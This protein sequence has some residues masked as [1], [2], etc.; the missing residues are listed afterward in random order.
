ML[1]QRQASDSFLR[2]LKAGDRLL[3]KD[4]AIFQF[5]AKRTRWR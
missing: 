5:G 3:M 4:D 2:D 1:R